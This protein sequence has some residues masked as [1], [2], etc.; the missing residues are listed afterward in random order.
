MITAQEARKRKDTYI[1]AYIQERIL[2]ATEKFQNHVHISSEG[3]NFVI[4]QEI[5]A[6]LEKLGYSV[7]YFE[8]NYIIDWR[9]TG[10]KL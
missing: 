5:I 6:G 9:D 7:R 10:K 8:K 4:S 1:L 2:K 3:G